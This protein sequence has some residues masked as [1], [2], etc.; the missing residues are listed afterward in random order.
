MNSR[1]A[2]E[3]KSKS[4]EWQS[5]FKRVSCLQRGSM[6][7]QLFDSRLL[8]VRWIEWVF[9][10]N[11]REW[12]FFS[13]LLFWPFWRRRNAT[14]CFACAFGTNDENTLT[15]SPPTSSSLCIALGFSGWY[16]FFSYCV[17]EPI[18][19]WCS[20]G[21]TLADDCSQ[22][23]QLEGMKVLGWPLTPQGSS[24]N[25]HKSAFNWSNETEKKYLEKS[26]LSNFP[27]SRRQRPIWRHEF[28]SNENTPYLGWGNQKRNDWMLFDRKWFILLSMNKY[29]VEKGET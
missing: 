8:R 4:M 20:R 10:V 14:E 19:G 26:W 29:L 25:C 17:A 12:F 18:V 1:A 5:L 6:Q 2:N 24:G 13:I 21:E 28:I 15:D 11:W 3:R 23:E 22:M 9:F 27:F 7:L 16:R